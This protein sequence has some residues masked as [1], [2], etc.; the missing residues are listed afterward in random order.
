MSENS[1]ERQDRERPRSLRLFVAIEIPR[2]AVTAVEAAFYP[3]RRAFPRIRWIPSDNWHL[4]LKFLGWTTPAQLPWV[5]G[6]VREVVTGSAPFEIR[7]SGVGAFPSARRARVL[8]AGLEDEGDALALLAGA[9]DAA[10]SPEFA[11]ETRSFSAHL[12]VGRSDPP[13][14]LPEG[15]ETTPLR[16]EAWRVD[17]VGL[18]RSHPQRPFPRY[19]LLSAD[20]LGG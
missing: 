3:W 1:E 8:W 6:R 17:R 2:A 10:T 15:F 13:A 5:Q 9:L 19:E 12:T 4:T 16:S 18:F 11:P 7:L 14:R 20:P